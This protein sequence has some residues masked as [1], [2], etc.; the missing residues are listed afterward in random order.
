M[1]DCATKKGVVL[2]IN[3]ENKWKSQNQGKLDP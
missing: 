1:A 3:E 2:R